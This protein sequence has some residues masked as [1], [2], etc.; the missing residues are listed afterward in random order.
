MAGL[1]SCRKA[2]KNIDSARCDFGEDPVNPVTKRLPQI[3]G[4]WLG[5]G[6]NE[7][8]AALGEFIE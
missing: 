8:A 1:W 5:M 2:I 3:G 6:Y 4:D 7:F